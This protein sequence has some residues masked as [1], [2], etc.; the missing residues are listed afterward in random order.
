MAHNAKQAYEQQDICL[1]LLTV[2]VEA[3]EGLAPKS[4]AP[5]HRL[6]KHTSG[7]LLAACDTEALR[8]IQTRIQAWAMQE[9]SL[10]LYEL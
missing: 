8:Y 2:M 10:V 4:L 5:C 1:S 7:L 3:Q 6:D 9:L